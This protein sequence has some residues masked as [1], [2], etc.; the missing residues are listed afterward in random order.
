MALRAQF[1]LVSDLPGIGAIGTAVQIDHERREADLSPRAPPGP[2]LAARGA[3]APAEDT[4]GTRPVF[5]HPPGHVRMTASLDLD[6]QETVPESIA[7][8]AHPDDFVRSPRF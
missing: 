3:R 5:Q 2:S 4:L 7:R 8:E 6:V 1:V